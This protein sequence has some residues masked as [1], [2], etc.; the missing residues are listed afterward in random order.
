MPDTGPPL[1]LEWFSDR[2]TGYEQK[3]KDD[4]ETLNAAHQFVLDTF[5]SAPLGLPPQVYAGGGGVVDLSAGGIWLISPPAPNTIISGIVAAPDGTCKRLYFT[6]T[7]TN[8]HFA[9]GPDQIL[10]NSGKNMNGIGFNDQTPI[11]FLDICYRTGSGWVQTDGSFGMGKWVPLPAILPFP[12]WPAPVIGMPFTNVAAGSIVPITATGIGLTVFGQAGGPGVN[13][14]LSTIIRPVGGATA[15]GVVAD[16]SFDPIGKF[17]VVN[18]GMPLDSLGA[19]EVQH[20]TGSATSV[21]SAV[22]TGYYS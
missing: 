22:V 17:G 12:L 21:S 10:V 8:I 4:M 7:N 19:F 11:S 14:V 18:G 2:E 3:F 1:N 5:A 9:P 15:A 6:N 16:Y 20:Q 13:Q